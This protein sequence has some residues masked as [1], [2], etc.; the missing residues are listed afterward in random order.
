MRHA[1][2]VAAVAVLMVVLASGAD[3]GS[4]CGGPSANQIKMG[5]MIVESQKLAIKGGELRKEAVAGRIPDKSAS[6]DEDGKREANW[7][8]L[9]QGERL[10]RFAKSKSKLANAINKMAEADAFRKKHPN[11]ASA[12]TLGM[13]KKMWTDE[14]V[15][16]VVAE[17]QF[18]MAEEIGKLSDWKRMVNQALKLDKDCIEAQGLNEKI[19]ALEEKLKEEAAAKRK[20]TAERRR[21][22][23]RKYKEAAAEKAKAAKTARDAKADDASDDD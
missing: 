15:R 7:I 6:R 3:A 10:S 18:R 21:E 9:K 14:Y 8:E 19:K 2:K 20:A 5:K 23:A 17:A 22:V 1:M 12:A 13:Y 16:T 11:A 4:C